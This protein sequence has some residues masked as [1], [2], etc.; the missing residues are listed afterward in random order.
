[1][2]RIPCI[3]RGSIFHDLVSRWGRFSDLYKNMTVYK[4][5]SLIFAQV[6]QFVALRDEGDA[7]TILVTSI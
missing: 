1:M 2:G 3:G 4:K 5:A 6:G 7:T